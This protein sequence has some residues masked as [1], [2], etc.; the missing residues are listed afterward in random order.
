MLHKVPTVEEKCVFLCVWKKKATFE[1]SR[2][3]CR[4]KLGAE[5]VIVTSTISQIIPSIDT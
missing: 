3:H 5:F 2:D 4:G 1:G